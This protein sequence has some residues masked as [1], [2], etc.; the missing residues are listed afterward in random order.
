[1]IRAAASRSVAV[2][3]ISAALLA[4]LASRV[5]AGTSSQQNPV[6]TFS[7]PGL[8]SVTLT[9]CTTGG[10]NTVTK[11]VLVLDPMPVVT[12]ASALVSSVEVGQF[13]PLT[14]AGT[15]KPPLAYTWRIF[16]GATLIQQLAGPTVWWSTAGRAPGPYTAVLH[17]ANSAGTTDSLALP[18]AVVA[19]KALDFYTVTPCR[20]L[21]TRLG[22]PL[23]AGIP[24]VL[25][26]AGACGIPAGARA[27][28]VNVTV[29]TPASQ[30]SLALYPGNYPVVGTSTINFTPGTTRANNAVLPLSTDGTT[31]LAA[32]ANLVSGGTI[33]LLIDVAGYFLIAP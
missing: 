6:A 16:Q 31:R 13:V 10:C 8:Q 26:L 33:D 2:L 7:T 3:A 17:I 1:M 5:E 15:G 28:A 22:S 12:T 20:A 14:G 25:N 18:V 4:G 19:P 9:A 21:D 27:V 32:V 30:G 23:A 24:Q 29:P 11:S